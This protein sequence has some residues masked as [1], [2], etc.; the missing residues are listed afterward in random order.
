MASART[1]CSAARI[2]IEYG[3]PKLGNKA[4]AFYKVV[5][6]PA[7]VTQ[8]AAASA[9]LVAAQKLTA[10]GFFSQSDTTRVLSEIA[11]QQQAPKD[12]EQE[13]HKAPAGIS[14]SW[15]QKLVVRSGGD[16]GTFR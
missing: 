6:P 13:E 12:D 10:S 7:L 2:E 16:G 15:Q 9:A 1:A 8:C 4:R 5:S 3:R 11:Q 14:N